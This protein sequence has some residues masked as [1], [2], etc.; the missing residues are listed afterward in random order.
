MLAHLS[1]N[2]VDVGATPLTL[3]RRLD[4]DSQTESFVG[5]EEAIELVDRRYRRPY[6][7][8]TYV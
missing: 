4:L 3:G 7:I 2:E 6:T 1:A 5:D 8:P